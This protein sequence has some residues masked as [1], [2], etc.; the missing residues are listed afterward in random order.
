MRQNQDRELRDIKVQDV[1]ITT[2][3]KSGISEKVLPRFTPIATGKNL[4]L[5]GCQC[6]GYM[7]G[8]FKSNG[9]WPDGSGS[10]D[11]LAHFKFFL[12]F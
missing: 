8:L 11:I 5:H 3:I 10:D 1:S 9:Y 2:L 6:P 7:F 12:Y 4:L